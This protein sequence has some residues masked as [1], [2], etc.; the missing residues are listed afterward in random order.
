MADSGG[1]HDDTEDDGGM[2]TEPMMGTADHLLRRTCASDAEGSVAGLY[3]AIEA[4]SSADITATLA[5]RSRRRRNATVPNL[6]RQHLL[7]AAS[8]PHSH[9]G[10]HQQ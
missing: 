10:F 2:A 8:G 1:T 9:R 3:Y 7:E 5:L 6:A 4:D